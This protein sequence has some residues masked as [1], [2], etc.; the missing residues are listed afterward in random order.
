M[1]FREA[2]EIVKVSRPGFWPTQL[3]FF[4]LP[5]AGQNMFGSIPFWLGAIYVCFPL[6]LLLYGWNDLGDAETDK[7][8]SRKDSWLFGARPDQQLRSRLPWIIAVIHAPFVIA[9]VIVAGPQMLVWFAA[10]LLTNTT[11]NNFGWKRLPALDLINQVGYLLIFVLA[12]WLCGLDQLSAPVMIFSAL[13]AMQ[14]HLF[15]QLMDL[16][17]DRL[18]GR[19]STAIALGYCQAKLLLSLLMW[20]EAAVAAMYFQGLAVS[21]FMTAGA[22]FFLGDAFVG[23]KRYSVSF[24][25]A[26]FI[27]W[28]VIAI[29]TMHLVWRYG[30]F[31]LAT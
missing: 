9:F 6:G 16:E 14:S 13:F 30:W 12:S 20:I 15:G 24:S 5:M 1:L 2:L 3:W 19:R 8:N 7:L 21:L 26:C 10:V 18:A 22:L 17:E 25:K 4:L 27:A 29:G 31:M 11:Y 28:N 23:P